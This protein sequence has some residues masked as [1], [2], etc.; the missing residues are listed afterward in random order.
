[1]PECPNCD[2]KIRM[3]KGRVATLAGHHAAIEEL[4]ILQ[5]RFDKFPF[6]DKDWQTFLTLERAMEMAENQ[7]EDFYETWC[8][9]CYEARIDCVQ[10]RAA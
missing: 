6:S 5:D 7:T 1:M 8:G 2:T 9:R 3:T 10:G 4:R